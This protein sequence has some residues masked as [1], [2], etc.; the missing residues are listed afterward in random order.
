MFETFTLQQPVGGN[1]CGAYALAALVNA[2]NNG[3]PVNTPTGASVYVDIIAQQ[4]ALPVGYPPI[5]APP[6]PRSLPSSLV[7]VGIARGFND[8]VQVMV[9]QALMPD[10]M[11]PLIAPETARIGHAAAVINSA[12][13]L[14]S[15]VQAA[16]YYLALVHDGVHW[17]ALGRN[18]QGFYAYDSD[19]DFHGATNQPVGN[20][21]TLNGVQYDF[22]GILICF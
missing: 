8:Q 22:S 19:A 7:H 17:I 15:M 11:L 9:N 20:Q 16:G 2:R 13:D 18:A 3:L 6:A 12:A 1:A 4:N 14:Q 5:F 21:L 10:E